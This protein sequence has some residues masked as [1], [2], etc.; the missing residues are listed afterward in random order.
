MLKKLFRNKSAL[1]FILL[2]F[3]L[4]FRGAGDHGLIDPVEG[5]NASIELHMLA[6]GNYFVPKIGEA[7]TAGHSLGTWWLSAFAISVFGWGEF[8]VR[9]WS[10]ISGL[11]MIFA[12]VLASRKSDDDRARKAWL[13][14]S[15]CAGMTLCFVVS[16]IA[17]S[18]ALYA[19]MTALVM[20]GI[21]RSRKNK[22]WLVLAHVA[23]TFAF[24]V[25]GF[26][27]M[28]LPFTAVIIYCVLCRDWE[29]L[30]DFFTWPAGIII[31]IFF[32]GIYFITIVL[33][34]PYLAHFMR[35]Q[36][37]AYTFGGIIGTI[38]FAFM[39]FAPY[40]G[41]ILRALYEVLPR[42][43][44]ARKSPELFMLVWA[45][46]FASA[47]FLSGDIL[48]LAA[49]IPAVSA[50][51]GIKIDSWLAQKKLLSIRFSV[52]ISILLLGPLLYILL[53]A[54]ILTGTFPAINAALISLIPWEI[55][56]GLFLFACWYYTKTRQITKW[57]RNVPA[58]AL[59]C[60]MPLAGIFNLTADVYSVRNIGMRLR[61]IIK[62]ND[63]VIQYSVNYPSIYFYSLRNSILIDSELT[64]GVEEKKFIMNDEMLHRIWDRNQ[65]IFLMIPQEKRP[66]NPLPQNIFHIIE[67]DGILLL[68]NQ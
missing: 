63:L 3:Y 24:I 6:S 47:A 41:F 68:S 61:D 34:N 18:H 50:I 31:T 29:L 56:T 57:V 45:F 8:A 60:L 44:P 51:L 26:E 16:Q 42:E 14:A 49:C 55:L 21:I 4:Y 38:I 59:L 46:V 58:A 5:I 36:N 67:D 66:E 33:V 9:F 27:G 48:S 28:L 22:K 10:V 52:M 53:P 32:C 40:H 64:G 43:Y 19:C 35:C 13:S 1:I 37:Y 54:I 20:A 65:R 25:H 62:G 15:V 39:S 11:G 30:K 2:L 7:L 23:L 12:C 17:S